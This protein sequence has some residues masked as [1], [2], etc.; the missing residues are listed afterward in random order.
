MRC[1]LLCMLEAV[2]SVRF[3]LK[4]LEVCG[5]SGGW[6]ATHALVVRKGMRHVVEV[7]EG[8]R[9]VLKVLVMLLRTMLMM[10]EVL[11]GACCVPLCVLEVIRH[12]L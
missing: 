8:M 7:L 10:L 3:V 11:E 6:W 5:G 12:V 1:V 2:E 9:H 4:L